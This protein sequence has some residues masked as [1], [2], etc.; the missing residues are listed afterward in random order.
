MQNKTH[1]DRLVAYFEQPFFI[2]DDPIS[3]CHAFSDKHDREIIG[4]YAATLAWGS[5]ASIVA[6]L[7]DLCTRMGYKPWNFVKDFDPTRDS[8]VLR[9]FVH[10]TFQPEDCIAFTH[11]LS[12]LMNQY[13]NVENIFECDPNSPDISESIE[14]FSLRMM[15][16]R[17]DTPS[18]LSKHLARP[19][20]NS[21]CKR[22]S[23][24]LRWM[25]RPGPVDLGIW[26]TIKP[27]QLLLPLD[28][29]SGRQARALGLLDRKMNDFKAV[30]ALTETCR[31]LD[32]HDPARYDYA[33][34]GLGMYG[35]PFND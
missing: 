24:Y 3:I 10:R 19:S 22:L 1:L 35:D 34:F 9:S 28:I 27:S 25:V 30:I 11:N 26:K 12:L 4:L 15:T 17:A 8:D 31:A 21:A 33:L 29:H 14:K 16:I 23:L 5:R 6:K 32:K 7:E 2:T 20:R 13:G 18:R